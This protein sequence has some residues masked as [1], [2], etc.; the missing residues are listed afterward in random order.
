MKRIICGLLAI[1]L[2][3]LSGCNNNDDD[4]VDKYVGNYK[5]K[6]TPDFNLTYPGYG[7]YNMSSDYEIETDCVIANNGKDVTVRMDGVNGVISDIEI[8]GY[9]DGLGMHLDD[10]AYEGFIRFDANNYVKCDLTLN[11]PNVSSPYNGTLSWEASVSGTCDVDVFGFGQNTQ[12]NTTGKISF[13]ASK[14]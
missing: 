8:T 13:A 7:S 12:C 2:L 9:C 4:Y 14:K 5:V 6:I 3:I 1:S 11:N 10:C